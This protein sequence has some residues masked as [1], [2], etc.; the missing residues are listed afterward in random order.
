MPARMTGA[1]SLGPSPSQP[2]E[3]G[4]GTWFSGR[5][6]S[7]PGCGRCGS[8]PYRTPK[9][10]QQWYASAHMGARGDG[11]AVRSWAT[12][13]RLEMKDRA[14]LDM[15]GYCGVCIEALTLTA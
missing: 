1:E 9:P 3:R 4:E 10:I 12:G 13:L 11:R 7:V 15:Q 6:P 14:Y 2:P 8:G 5:P